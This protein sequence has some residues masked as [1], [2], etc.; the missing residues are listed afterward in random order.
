MKF[1]FEA[2]LTLGI[3]LIACTSAAQAQTTVTPTNPQGWTYFDGSSGSDPAKITGTQPFNGNG[4]LEFDINA[5]NQ[6]PTAAFLFAN[7]VSLSS[8]ASMSLGWSLLGPSATIRL[9]LTNITNGNQPG[10]RTDGSLGWF[11][12][13]T[14]SSWQTESFSLTSGDFF[15]RIGGKGQAADDCTSTGS[16]F[17]DRRQTV[18]TWVSTC[19]GAGGTIDIDTALITGVQVDWGTF[20]GQVQTISSFADMVNFSV[21]TNTGNFNFELDGGSPAAVVPEPGTMTLLALGL[22]GLA[23]GA[24]RRKR[25]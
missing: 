1:R 16:S 2:A 3:A 11:L 12:D 20:P 13:G 23:S 4:S 15:F 18:A 21:G 17:G 19:N 24:R 25:S 8:L 6:Q 10:G 9:L 22:V 14:S 5:G 7:P